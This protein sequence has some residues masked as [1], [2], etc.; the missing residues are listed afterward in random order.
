LLAQILGIALE[1]KIIAA[2]RSFFGVHR[3]TENRKFGFRQL[4]HGNT[5][6]GRQ[7]LDP[8]KQ[9]TPLTYYYP[10]GPIGQVMET[11]LPLWKPAHVGLVGL[12]VGSLASYGRPGDQFTFFEIDPIVIEIASNP[13]LFTYVSDCKADLKIVEGDARLSLIEQP[14]QSFDLLVLDAF[15]SDSIP[16]HLLTVEAIQL[17]L[18][19]LKPNGILA[20][21]V[22]NRYLKLSPVLAG[23]AERLGKPVRYQEDVSLSDEEAIDGKLRSLYFL[24][25]AS[26][27]SFAPMGKAIRWDKLNQLDTQTP[28][29][30]E[31]S[32]ILEAWNRED[33]P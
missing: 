14:D 1:G 12:G 9:K 32:N 4:V 26:E 20:F 8:K 15:S 25:G 21:H 18:K 5:I 16:V 30:D 28:W 2:E 27:E 11:Y 3:V 33:Y 10:T 22:S 31:R 23:A 24:L 29:T 19:K 7:H 6:H 17:Y 13:K